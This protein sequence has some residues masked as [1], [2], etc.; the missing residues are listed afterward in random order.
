MLEEIVDSVTPAKAAQMLG[1]HVGTVHRW[2]MHG[3]RGRTLPSILVGGR[4]RILTAQLELFLSAKQRAAGDENEK[5]D[6]TTHRHR[7]AQ[8]QLRSFGVRIAPDRQG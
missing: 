2:M 6:E 5:R 7:D 8:N 4:R 1:V 3:V